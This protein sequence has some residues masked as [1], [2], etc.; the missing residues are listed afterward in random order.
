VLEAKARHHS[1]LVNGVLK[2]EQ[3]K[4]EASKQAKAVWEKCKGFANLK[5]KF[6]SLLNAKKGGQRVVL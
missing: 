5:R 2:C 6:P 1:E 3:Q 4:C